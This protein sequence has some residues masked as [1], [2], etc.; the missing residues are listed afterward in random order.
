[1]P[2]FEQLLNVRENKGAGFFLLL[3]P[4]RVE[5]SRLVDVSESAQAFGVDAILAGSSTVTASNYDAR[6]A[7][8]KRA[9]ELPVVI[10]PGSSGQ[11]SKHADGI[12]FLSL[13]SGRNPNYLIEE[14]VKGA[15]LIKAYGLEPI[16][17]GYMLIESG[18]LTS[19]Q[20][21][22]G[23]LPIPR[24]KTD[25]AM[26]HA[27]AANYLGMKMVY[28]EA[29]SGA[30]LSVPEEMVTA[31]SE[32]CG[33]PVIVGGGIKNPDDAS[34]LVAAG[35]SFIVIGTRLEFENDFGFMSEMADAI[36]SSARTII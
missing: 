26:V 33:L 2:L 15:P 18:K 6:M 3:D 12:L 20:Y 10:F 16:P 13:I 1:M 30:E 21:V 7:E 11:V 8:I 31:V 5:K 23:T 24:K 19:V 22:S 29:G 32:Y 14:Q 35:A 34:K 4:D 27:L 9:T 25:I 28:L 36:H 17:T